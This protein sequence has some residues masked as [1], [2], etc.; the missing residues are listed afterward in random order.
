[1]QIPRRPPST[2]E[3][4]RTVIEADRIAEVMAGAQVVDEKGRYLHWDDFRFKPVRDG[5]SVE[6]AWI[7]MRLAR[8]FAAQRLPLL[9]A[10]GKPIT[11]CEPPKV[12]SSLRYLDMNA[13]GSLGADTHALSQGEGRVHLARSLAEEPF[14]SSF[15]EGA[16]TTRQ[17]AK[18]LILEGREPRTRD[19]LMVLNNY[20]AMQFVKRQKDTP[21]SM[22]FLLELHRI[23]TAGTLDDDSDAGRL[24]RGDDVQ[25]VDDSTGEI[26]HQPPLRNA[27]E[28][29]LGSLFTFANA[30][31][32]ADQWLHPLLRAILLHFMLAYEHPFLDGNGR[33]ARALFYWSALRS[34]YWLME[35]ISISSVIAE[36][37]I[38]YGR[39]FLEVETDGMDATY[40]VVHQ[41]AILTTALERFGR[42]I[43]TKRGEV[44]LIEKVLE[45]R[46]GPFA[47][48]HRQAWLLN[49]LLRGRI[50]RIT[51]GE[52]EKKQGVSYLTARADLERL[53][54]RGYLRKSK[55]GQTSIYRP[56]SGLTEKLRA[57]R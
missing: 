38:Q 10:D 36:A 35:Y 14:A 31:P 39:A 26:L 27:L 28:T 23:V 51:I 8:Q 57:R 18:K 32:C 45:R 54:E 47:F 17:I 53:T 21:L 9:A 12:R 7:A 2:D 43:E 30:E 49:E 4:L 5:V 34:G 29:R 20:R 50:N 33:V 56:A 41:V 13:G 55:A 1:M 46:K 48:N 24:R 15:I 19:E 52:H 42:Y 16:A 25:V 22:E 11:Y 44:R 37:K 6:E 3:L 40:F